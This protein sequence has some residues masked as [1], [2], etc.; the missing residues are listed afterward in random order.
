VSGLA[1]ATR[2]LTI[3][4]IGRGP[5]EVDGA[6]LGRAVPWFP[7]VGLGIGAVLAG[8]D[9]LVDALFPGLLAALLA[10]TVWKLLT[11]G[12]HLDGLA[13][14]LDGLGG[15]DPAQ[16][17]HIMRDSRIGAFGTMG[18]IL[19]LLL[20]IAALAELAGRARWGTLLAAPAVGRATPA[21][22]AAVFP[23][24]KSEGQGARFQA[25]VRRPQ[26]AVG[27]AIAAAAAAACLGTA[28]IAALVAGLAIALGAGAFLG[29]R[30]GGITGDVLGA[31]VELSELAVLLAMVAWTRL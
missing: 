2:Y 24:A 16:R 22:L 6:A 13:D 30:L 23:A 5:R 11:G 28:G 4:P 31:A 7:V 14:C 8:F 26:A 15:W 29:R 3:A 9:R 17:L 21:I 1:L 19:F 10:V 27:V 18:L 25:A 20:E 12:L